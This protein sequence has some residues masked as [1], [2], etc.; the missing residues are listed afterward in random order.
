MP[1]SSNFHIH[2]PS[3]FSF[4]LSV[5]DMW[6][7]IPVSF[8]IF[9]SNID[10]MIVP[11]KEKSYISTTQAR[12]TKTEFAKNNYN[13]NFSFF[14]LPLNALSMEKSLLWF[15][16]IWL[17]CLN[18]LPKIILQAWNIVLRG[19]EFIGRGHSINQISQYSQR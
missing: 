17:L 3:N 13:C 2:F 15:V 16:F 1:L 5:N 12:I 11:I 14:R 19:L 9:T 18:K 6:A 10:K 7:D 8:F 4:I